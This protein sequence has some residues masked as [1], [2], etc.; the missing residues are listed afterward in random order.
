MAV[1]LEQFSREIVN[2]GVMSAGELSDYMGT[3]PA[4][5]RPQDA[6]ALARSLVRDGR[7]TKY[8][9]NAL[10]KGEGAS[11]VLGP[12]LVQ[13]KL[14]EG[15]MG[16]VLKAVHRTTGRA[17]AVK[18]LRPS[19]LEEAEAVK[20]FRQEVSVASRLSHGNI[21][22][23]LDSGEAHG[24]HYMAMEFVEGRD[25]AALVTED[26]P[27][28]LSKAL[29]CVIQAARGLEYAHSQGAIHRDIKPSNLLLDRNGT[30]KILDMGLAR[31]YETEDTS[32]GTT[33]AQRLTKRGEMLGTVDYMS[34][35]QAVDTR[36]VDHRADIYS[37]GC[38]LY[39]LLTSKPVYEADSVIQKLIAH[40]EAEIPSLRDSLPDAP[41]RLN[42][43][44]TK[45]VAKRPE[46][47][48]QTM[49]EAIADLQECLVE[50]ASAI[51]SA[52][53]ATARRPA[54]A[55]AAPKDAG[56]FTRR[57]GL[58]SVWSAGERGTSGKKKEPLTVT[59]SHELS[60][61]ISDSTVRKSE[62]NT[63]MEQAP[64]SD[65]SPTA[66]NSRSTVT[67]SPVRTLNPGV[68]PKAG[69]PPSASAAADPA[70]ATVDWSTADVEMV[71]QISAA[72]EGDV[73]REPVI[74]SPPSSLTPSSQMAGASAA[75]AIANSA[76]VVQSGAGRW[77]VI[78]AVV[79][80]LALLGLLAYLV[81]ML[82]R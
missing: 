6:D 39:R 69:S 33:M 30:I 56:D 76:A 19:S 57:D 68:A 54:A 23:T 35:E 9:I 25:L 16:Q 45:M 18:V 34:P 14:G 4:E 72:A 50:E 70:K 8:Q 52:L 47:R 13:S 55:V 27:F 7:M 3:F 17:V 73:P 77:V 48:Y 49:F 28:P 62:P 43:V 64:F 31:I 1:P 60:Q 26:G 41:D 21:V 11:L 59:G 80:G 40:S 32:V 61:V 24:V 53:P 29:D 63:A 22:E 10:V 46:D 5:K 2:S 82:L 71:A 65:L 79:G 66:Q 78:G 42:R 12:Y 37:L 36:S 81:S 15:G 67:E 44:F 38:T 74:S 51:R 75:T 58:T 20:R